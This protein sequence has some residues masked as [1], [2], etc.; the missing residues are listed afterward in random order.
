MELYFCESH[1][2]NSRRHQRN[3]QTLKVLKIFYSYNDDNN[4]DG[5]SIIN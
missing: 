3:C 2:M 4:V 1:E 5:P